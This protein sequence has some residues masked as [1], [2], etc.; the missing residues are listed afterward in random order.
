[1]SS[2]PIFTFGT[3]PKKIHKK[4]K[5]SRSPPCTKINH[6]IKNNKDEKKWSGYKN[7]RENAIIEK[8]GLKK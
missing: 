2:L 6:T 1:M 5:L 3:S 8:R 4:Y 7:S